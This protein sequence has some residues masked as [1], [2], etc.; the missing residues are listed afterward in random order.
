M[1]KSEAPRPERSGAD[2][3]LDAFFDS[4][5]ELETPAEVDARLLQS[6]QALQA[7]TQENTECK[8]DTSIPWH[9]CVLLAL[10]FAI[11][12]AA[13]PLKVHSRRGPRASPSGMRESL[14]DKRVQVRAF[15]RVPD[16]QARPL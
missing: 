10:L 12:M 16:T 7:A 2:A 14:Q 5:R 9:W 15:S 1:T 13:R 3:A 4:A 6:L 8:P 11:A